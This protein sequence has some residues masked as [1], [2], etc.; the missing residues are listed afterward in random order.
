[1]RVKILTFST[2]LQLMLAATAAF[3]QFGSAPN[4]YYPDGYMGTTFTGTVTA[5]KDGEITLTYT[6][7]D[8]T[9][10]FVGHLEANCNAPTANGKGMVAADLLMGTV[11]TAFFNSETRK[12]NGQKLKDNVIIAVSFEVWRGQK[13]PDDKKKI[14]MCTNNK[15]L[16]FKAW[17]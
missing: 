1:M 4:S 6:R 7:K 14:Y 17:H 3:A 15:H 9:D 10:T 12:V 2:C 11:I 13:I 16:Q 5:V 8:K